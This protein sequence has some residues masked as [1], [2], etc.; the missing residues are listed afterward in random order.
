MKSTRKG[1]KGN[2]RNKRTRRNL[3]K[4]RGGVGSYNVNPADLQGDV[5]KISDPL[6]PAG[7]AYYI[8]KDSG[9]DD[10]R[11]AMTFGAII[12]SVVGDGLSLSKEELNTATEALKA[13][14]GSA[15]ALPPVLE[16]SVAPV[17]VGSA[18]VSGVNP[19]S[20]VPGVAPG[21]EEEEEGGLLG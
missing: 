10:V 13:P 2:R 18:S 4:M 9:N 19:A 20:V 17:S 5:I 11:R 8:I 14:A 15:S 21:S 1:G 7:A 16:A 3:R 12:N 6:I